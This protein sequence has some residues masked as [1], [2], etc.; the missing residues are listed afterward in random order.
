MTN[1]INATA[2]TPQ[3]WIDL[4]RENETL[5]QQLESKMTEQRKTVHDAVEWNKSK[6]F[7]TEWRYGLKD[8]I[9]FLDG[10][11]AY[12]SSDYTDR[13]IVCTRE[14]FEEVAV[15]V[16]KEKDPYEEVSEGLPYILTDA[17]G[18]EWER[19]SKTVSS[20]TWKKRKPTITK[21]QA[22]KVLDFAE[23]IGQLQVAEQWIDLNHTIVD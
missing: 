17:N 4:V 2:P 1:Q 21:A 15:A 20:A 10:F 23:S 7:G 6:G 14:E 5:R 13:D 22:G 3:D 12:S 18:F 11:F 8:C 19:V 16:D 9:T